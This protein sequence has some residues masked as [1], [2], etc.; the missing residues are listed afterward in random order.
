MKKKFLFLI[1][2]KGRK[3]LRNILQSYQIATLEKLDQSVN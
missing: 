3:K 2:Y 1:E